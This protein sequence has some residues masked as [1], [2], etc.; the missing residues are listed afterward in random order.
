MESQYIV[1]LLGLG[2]WNWKFSQGKFVKITLVSQNI[3][4]DTTN[5]LSGNDTTTLV[6]NWG[7]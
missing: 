4:F 7:Q 1:S 6:N 2:F 5:T 3:H